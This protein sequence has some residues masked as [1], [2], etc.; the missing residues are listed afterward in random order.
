MTNL[1]EG[2]KN[3]RE[4]EKRSIQESK[5]MII[6][7]REKEN[8]SIQEAKKIIIKQNV[9]KDLAG[10]GSLEELKGILF[11]FIDEVYDK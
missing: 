2:L 9:L 1:A 8:C 3:I 7:I 11:Y 4:K 6:N 10:A 5:K